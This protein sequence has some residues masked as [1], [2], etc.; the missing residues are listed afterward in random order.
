MDVFIE[1]IQNN[2]LSIVGVMALMVIG[3]LMA[4]IVTALKLKQTLARFRSLL[5]GGTP[6]GLE[7]VLL[8]NQRAL[9]EMRSRLLEVGGAVEHLAGVAS[10]RLMG[11]GLVR[12]Q[13]FEDTGSDLSFAWALL[14]GSGDGVVVCS[15][16]GREESRIYAK[17][18]RARSSTYHLTEEEREAIRLATA[19]F[20]SGE[21]T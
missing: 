20:S 1:W 8:D 13:A 11:T 16:Y 6:E 21:R 12:F 10:R 7:G 17:P 5:A 3:L 18:V 9:E 15:L 14:D 4:E 19:V 2:L